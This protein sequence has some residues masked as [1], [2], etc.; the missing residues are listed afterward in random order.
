[1]GNP[2]ALAHAVIGDAWTQLI[3]REAF[4]GVRRFTD[5]STNLRI[6]RTVLSGRLNRLVA[7]GIM[8][9]KV[10]PG[11]KRG[12]YRLTETGLDLY[13][14]ALM[15]GMWERDHA[16]SIL[17]RRYALSF[18]DARTGKPIVP[19][20][21]DRPGGK[22]V[23]PR[24]VGVVEGPG[25]IE[26]SAPAHRRWSGGRAPAERPMIERSVDIIG[27]H[28]S[29]SILACAFLRIRRFDDMLEATGMAPNI[30]SDRLTRLVG[31]G[32]LARIPYQASPVRH[33][34]RL[35]EA[36]LELYPVVLAMHGWAERWL[37]DFDDPPLKL[38][39]LSTG[40]RITPAVCDL[41]TGEPIRARTTRWRLEAPGTE[42]PRPQP[43]G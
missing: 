8:E 22:P 31:S 27:D 15:Q 7:A 42:R 38:V 24:D 28:W 35:T 36:G 34:Y 5:W 19:K 13:G 6:P 3:L 29:W 41:L 12:E 20:V 30:L 10:P 39:H 9:V 11:A 43:A 21:L 25:L 32:I 17:Q 14:V 2:L 26:R 23:D 37:C 16:P 18:H 1:M 40:E 33:E 4:H